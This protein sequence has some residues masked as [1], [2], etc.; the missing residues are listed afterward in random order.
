MVEGLKF[1]SRDVEL[2]VKDNASK[3]V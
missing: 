2:K 1:S 3:R